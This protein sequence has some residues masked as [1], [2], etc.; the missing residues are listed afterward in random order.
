MPGLM[1]QAEIMAYID[2]QVAKKMAKYITQY[3][4]YL[5]YFRA[6]EDLAEGEYLMPGATVATDDRP[7]VKKN[8][9]DG[10]SGIG[11]AYTAVSVGELVPVVVS[12]LGY[13]L[14]E[15]GVT[16]TRGY[17]AYSSNAEAGRVDQQNTAP[18]NGR[19]IGVFVETGSGAGV[20]ALAVISKN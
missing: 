13:L 1:N 5:V 7:Y 9:V 8:A 12:G 11:A 2:V 17:I 14:P 6:E 3:G 10:V 18:D 4:G 19:V 16:A 20:D 15:S